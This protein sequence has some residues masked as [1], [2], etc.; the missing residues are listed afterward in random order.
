MQQ[1][2]F[3]FAPS[4]DNCIEGAAEYAGTNISVLSS[5][6][7]PAADTDVSQTVCGSEFHVT[8]QETVKICCSV[9]ITPDECAALSTHDEQEQQN[10]DEEDR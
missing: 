7:N 1:R 10:E 6:L 5:L 4:H 9:R 8:G 2:G 3:V